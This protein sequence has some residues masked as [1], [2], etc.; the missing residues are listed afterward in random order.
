[1]IAEKTPEVMLLYPLS[2]KNLIWGKLWGIW[3]YSLRTDVQTKQ[4]VISV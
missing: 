2:M 3:K 1:M 4:K